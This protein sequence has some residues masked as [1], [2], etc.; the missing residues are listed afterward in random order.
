MERF[1]ERSLY[2]SRN[3][4]RMELKTYGKGNGLVETFGLIGVVFDKSM[5]DI[6]GLK[7]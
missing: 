1:G 3:K 4:E 5:G 6:G 2:Q 7:V